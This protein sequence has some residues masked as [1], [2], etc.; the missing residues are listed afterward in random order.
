MKPKRKRGVSDKEAIS[1]VELGM[2]T[3]A[4]ASN[5][6]HSASPSGWVDS[7]RPSPK[8]AFRAKGRRSRFARRY[9]STGE[10]MRDSRNETRKGRRAAR[11]SWD[12][13]SSASVMGRTSTRRRERLA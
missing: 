2:L 1:G 7:A 4:H 10:G 3:G 12:V 5:C 6:F 11:V 13:D 9:R 8:N